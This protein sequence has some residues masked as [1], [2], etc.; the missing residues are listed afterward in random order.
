MKA[1]SKLRFPQLHL[2]LLDQ[3]PIALPADKNEELAH[4]LVELL[5]S[6]TSNP[7]PAAEPKASGGPDEP[8]ADN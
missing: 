6:A 3:I 5:I 7:T 1:Q 2:P 8:Q 4:A